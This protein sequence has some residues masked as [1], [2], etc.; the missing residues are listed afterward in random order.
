[1]YM[2]VYRTA[3]SNKEPTLVY[4]KKITFPAFGVTGK[5][6]M[7]FHHHSG[8]LC[9]DFKGHI[10]ELVKEFMLEPSHRDNLKYDIMKVGLTPVGQSLDKL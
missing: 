10:T 1:M 3:K 8:I 2:P 6:D 7:I 9:D 5:E 4:L